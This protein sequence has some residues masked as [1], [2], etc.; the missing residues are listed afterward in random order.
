M[1]IIGGKWAFSSLGVTANPWGYVNQ[2]ATSGTTSLFVKDI[3]SASDSVAAM[4]AGVLLPAGAFLHFKHA[5]LFEFDAGPNFYD[6]GVLEYSVNDGVSWIDA[7][8]LFSA[9]KDYGGA[10]FSGAGASTLAGRQAFVADSHGYVSSRYDLNSLAGQTVRF[11]FRQANDSIVGAFGW[12]VD[13]VRIYTCGNGVD[14]GITIADAPDP[15]PFGSNLTYT[16]TASNAG[17]DNAT[18]VRVTDVLLGF[19]G[20][21][22]A[23]PSQGSCSGNITVTCSL[24]T[25]AIGAQAT[26]SLVV[27]P[28]TTGTVSNTA[29]VTS[30]S[31]DLVPATTARRPRRR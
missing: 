16:I 2:Y 25:I 28:F 27:Q 10:I 9:G 30:A 20:F 1:E 21:V 8:T 31:T 22:S 23:T 12:F 5:F 26:V 11:R 13:D 19:V 15:L 24:G 18:Q 14:L 7:R 29:T 6:G 17:P 4:S 3:G